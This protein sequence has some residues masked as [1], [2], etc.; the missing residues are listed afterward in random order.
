M[1]VG[2]G[3]LHSAVEGVLQ[4][5]A[6]PCVGD[7][8]GAADS[9]GAGLEDLVENLVQAA[10]GEDGRAAWPKVIVDLACLENLLLVAKKRVRSLFITAWP[11]PPITKGTK[12]K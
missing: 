11:W 4:T 5:L 6:N 8:A 2:G 10:M 7:V 3:R 9:L 1:R 12:R